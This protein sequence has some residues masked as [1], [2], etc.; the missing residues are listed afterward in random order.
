MWSQLIDILANLAKQ[1]DIIVRL[2][3]KKRSALIAV[4]FKTVDTIRKAEEKTIAAIEDLE[5]QRVSVVDFIIGERAA[6]YAEEGVTPNR[7][8]IYT[9]APK[10][11]REP[12]FK[13]SDRL[14]ERVEA[15][16]EASDGNRMILE[17]A[18]QAVI[19]KM[20][21]ISQTTVDQSYGSAGQEN[22]TALRRSLN[23]DA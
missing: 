19:Y 4:D 3:A 14:S 7:F 21:R 13:A 8:L 20:N 15:A 16:K 23:Y 18:L 2:A 17:S 1:Y 5:Q 11:Y 22:T 10:E 6:V 12:L 9:L